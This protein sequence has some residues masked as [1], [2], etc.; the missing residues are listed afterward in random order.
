MFGSRKLYKNKR[1]SFLKLKFYPKYCYFR[2]NLSTYDLQDLILRGLWHLYV[3]FLIYLLSIIFLMLHYL[4]FKVQFKEYEFFM[5][6]MRR[7]ELLSENPSTQLSSWTVCYLE[8]PS[9]SANRHAIPSGSPFLH[10][11]LKCERPMHVHH[12]NDA[13]SE[14]VVLIGGTGDP[15]VTA[16]PIIE[17]RRVNN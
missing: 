15:Q 14:A 4:V 11:R 13:Q 3:F 8:F 12:S 16:L 5:V 1:N 10:D 6:E 7:I 2:K 17:P 9:G